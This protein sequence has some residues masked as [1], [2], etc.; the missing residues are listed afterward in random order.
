MRSLFIKMSNLDKFNYECEGQI[1]MSEY[2]ATKIKCGEVK[3][4]T[5][6]INS[7]GK[8]QYEQIGEVVKKAF[9]DYKDDPEF[10]DRLTNV[11]S[12]Y[13]LKQ[14]EGYMKYLKS[15]SGVAIND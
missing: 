5:C 6:W 3:D 15:E 4:L 12:I 14:S 8:A 11:I 1:E 10:V 7:Q 9:D 2:L 13:V